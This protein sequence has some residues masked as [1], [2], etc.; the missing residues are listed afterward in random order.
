MSRVLDVARLGCRAPWPPWALICTK[1]GQSLFPTME[2]PEIRSVHQKSLFSEGD[3]DQ[4]IQHLR[5]KL[6]RFFKTDLPSPQ[7]PHTTP[8]GQSSA[9]TQPPI[10]SKPSQ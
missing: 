2:I 7:E 9:D 3:S 6:T 8:H 4:L 5:Q 1:P 10:I